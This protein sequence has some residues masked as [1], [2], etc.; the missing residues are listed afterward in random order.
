MAAS[1][2]VVG[3]LSAYLKPVCKDWLDAGL[4]LT[5]CSPDTEP[6]F[7]TFGDETLTADVRQVFTQHVQAEI[8]FK[9]ALC[10]RF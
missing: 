5:I 9:G 6:A 4:S 1:H 2:D 8:D 3:R 7:L 10:N